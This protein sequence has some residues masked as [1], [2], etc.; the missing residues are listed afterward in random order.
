MFMFKILV[1][2][3]FFGLSGEQ[4]QYQILDR[5]SFHDFHD[6][7]EADTVPDQ[8]TIRKSNIVEASFVEVPRQRNRFAKNESIK[9]GELP[10]GWEN[11]PNV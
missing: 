2:Q 6:T 4:T 8:N 3:F 9:N 1:L 7:S 11:D 5:R 10:E